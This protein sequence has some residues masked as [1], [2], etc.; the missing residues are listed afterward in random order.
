M[1]LLTPNGGEKLVLELIVN[2]TAAQDLTL[3]LFSNDVTPAET[4]TIS[5][6]TENAESGY[7]AKTL[8]GASWDTTSTISTA[9]YAAQTFS[10]TTSATSYGYFVKHGSSL[11]LAERFTGAP[12]N[13]P[14]GG[15][16]ISVTP[17]I[18]AD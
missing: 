16:N 13:I 18:S 7:S 4:D 12:F 8:T 11:L 5:T 9:S 14:S 17:T 2:K 10:F 3:H 1:A 15:G 6:Y